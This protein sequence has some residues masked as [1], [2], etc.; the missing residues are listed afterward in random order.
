MR[1]VKTPFAG[2]SRV[3][4]REREHGFCVKAVWKPVDC[5]MPQSVWKYLTGIRLTDQNIY[6]I[7]YWS[8]SQNNNNNAWNQN[9]S[10]GQ[11]GNLT[12]FNEI[13]LCTVAAG[14][15]CVRN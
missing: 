5:F 4:A 3:T 14:S 8:S 12:I 7:I 15:E 1:R 10:N 2:F 9:F 13:A 11:G 6:T